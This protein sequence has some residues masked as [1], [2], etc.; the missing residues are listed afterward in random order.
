MPLHFVKWVFSRS[1]ILWFWTCWIIAVKSAAIHNQTQTVHQHHMD[2]HSIS[3]VI[4]MSLLIKNQFMPHQCDHLKC[5]NIN[6][7]YNYSKQK[8]IV[9]LSFSVW[10]SGPVGLGLEGSR[11][12][13]CSWLRGWFMW[14]N[15]IAILFFVS[16]LCFQPR[17]VRVRLVCLPESVQRCVGDPQTTHTHTHTHTLT[18]IVNLRIL[19]SYIMKLS[20]TFVLVCVCVCGSISAVCTV[21]C[22]NYK[23]KK[24]CIS[25]S[26]SHTPHILCT[27]CFVGVKNAW[28]GRFIM[29][30]PV[31]WVCDG[32]KSCVLSWD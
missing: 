7:I 14:R 11:S 27:L 16:S 6:T 9:K 23:T 20:H 2:Y 21:N 31:W 25:F 1:V 30:I 3:C 10:L 19:W 28:R 24:R 12:L 17:C 4:Q 5:Y 18:H 29:D 13:C 22:I 26:R 32:T 8:I 15:L